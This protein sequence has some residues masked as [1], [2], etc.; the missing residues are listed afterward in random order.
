MEAVTSDIFVS[1]SDIAE[2]LEAS[3]VNDPDEDVAETE[4]EKNVV[5]SLYEE[6]KRKLLDELQLNEYIQVRYHTVYFISSYDLV[7]YVK[8]YLK[9]KKFAGDIKKLLTTW[10]YYAAAAAAE[11]I[12]SSE[13]LTGV[14]LANKDN[15][16]NA[17]KKDMV[18]MFKM[19][20]KK[21]RVV[22]GFILSKNTLL[23]VI[24]K[25]KPKAGPVETSTKKDAK[26]T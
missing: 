18:W 1:K 16:A 22:K 7:A 5:W 23:Q 17:T 25:D 21:Q 10:N 26:K 24:H 20:K 8:Q 11:V 4:K 13:I 6:D 12:E 3:D 19:C 15:I 2:L 9:Q 14:L